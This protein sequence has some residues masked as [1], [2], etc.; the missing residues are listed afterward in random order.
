MGISI[1]ITDPHLLE[2]KQAQVLVQ[3]I[4]EISGAEPLIQ[5]VEKQE[6]FEF[7]DIVR[8]DDRAIQLI[9]R[10]VQSQSLI[11]ALKGTSEELREKIF[12]NMSPRAAEMVREDFEALRP[13]RVTE[14]IGEQYEIINVALRLANEGQFSL[15]GGETFIE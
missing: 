10:E 11:V 6:S 12:K 9:L 1:T 13:I 8:L 3:F 15:E 2:P 5:K 4:L 7:E 14:V